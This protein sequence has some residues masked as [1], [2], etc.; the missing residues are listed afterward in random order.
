MNNEH[1]SGTGGLDIKESVPVGRLLGYIMAETGDSCLIQ[2]LNTTTDQ[3]MI[4]S[5]RE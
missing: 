2:P 3:G 4:G 1:A 5:L